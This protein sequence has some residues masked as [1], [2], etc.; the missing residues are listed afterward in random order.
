MIKKQ[1]IERFYS[2]DNDLISTFHVL[3]P[4]SLSEAVDHTF[5]AIKE[6]HREGAKTFVSQH[7]YA[8]IVSEGQYTILCAFF[9]D[10]DHRKDEIIKRR[11]MAMLGLHKVTHAC[12]WDRNIRAKRF[13][14]KNNFKFVRNMFDDTEKQE[15]CIYEKI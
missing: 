11:F 6:L 2:K 7:W 15:Y 12:V 4:T 5:N 1:D 13:F 9:I 14:E 3:A 8:T 10:C